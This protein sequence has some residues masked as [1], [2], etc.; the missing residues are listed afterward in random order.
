MRLDDA[1]LGIPCPAP[2]EMTTKDL[3]ISFGAACR[4]FA[5]LPAPL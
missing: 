1:S 2:F 5:N 3:Q 4:V